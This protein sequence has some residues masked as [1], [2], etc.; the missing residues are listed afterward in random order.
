M[1]VGNGV[2]EVVVMWYCLNEFEKSK[3]SF[4]TVVEW[5]GMSKIL[6][7]LSRLWQKRQAGGLP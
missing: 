5:A 3:K 2:G 4:L 6:I 1:T 7:Q